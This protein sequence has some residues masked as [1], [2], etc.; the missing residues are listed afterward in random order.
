MGIRL[1]YV[2]FYVKGTLC[3]DGIIEPKVCYH[4]TLQIKHYSNVRFI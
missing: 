3:K 2:S 1:N 4:H